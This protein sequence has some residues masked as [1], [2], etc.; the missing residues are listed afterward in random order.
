MYKKTVLDFSN[1]DYTIEGFDYRYNDGKPPVFYTNAI[2][3]VPQ[4]KQAISIGLPYDRALMNVEKKDAGMAKYV[5]KVI[6]GYS[7]KPQGELLAFESLEYD[8]FDLKQFMM[9][10]LSGIRVEIEQT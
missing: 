7:D 6:E 2:L 8:G 5:R 1:M 4:F 9:H 3:K 10:M